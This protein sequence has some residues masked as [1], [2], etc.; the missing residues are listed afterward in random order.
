MTWVPWRNKFRNL[1]KTPS[2][3]FKILYILLWQV[4]RHSKLLPQLPLPKQ[5]CQWPTSVPGTHRWYTWIKIEQTCR[6]GPTRGKRIERGSEL[7]WRNPTYRIA[8]K[9]WKNITWWQR[10][11]PYTAG[12]SSPIGTLAKYYLNQINWKTT[13]AELSIFL[14]DWRMT[15]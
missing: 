11:T 14:G 6:N 2:K 10:S 8:T 7:P 1:T 12:H 9:S 4:H 13:L 5:T 3:Q 15:N